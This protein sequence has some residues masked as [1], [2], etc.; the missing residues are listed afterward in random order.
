MNSLGL[1][2][3]IAQ[4]CADV[5]VFLFL[6][7]GASNLRGHIRRQHRFRH[8]LS[9][10]ECFFLSSTGSSNSWSWFFFVKYRVI[11]CEVPRRVFKCLTKF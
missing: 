9:A 4:L 1:P 7:L 11:S 3:V 5:L 6:V 10:C 8:D 2:V